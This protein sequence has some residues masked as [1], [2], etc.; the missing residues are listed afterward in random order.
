MNNPNTNQ[1]NKRALGGRQEDLACRFLEQQGILILERNYRVK[2]GEIDIIAKE[3]NEICFI[4][5]KYRASRKYGGA[6]YAISHQKQE[7][8]RR[9]A[10]WYISSHHLGNNVFFRF[11]AVLI[12]GDEIQYIRNAW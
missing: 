11:D 9:V 7:K 10:Q 1:N 6:S 4:E 3:G 12:D 8:I 5:V 2:I